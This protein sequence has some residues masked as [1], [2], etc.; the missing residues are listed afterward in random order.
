MLHVPTFIPSCKVGCTTNSNLF[1]KNL[2]RILNKS[3][4]C[5]KI[6]KEIY[7]YTHTHTQDEKSRR[8]KASM[9]IYKEILEAN[10]ETKG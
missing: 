9:D 5:F 2:I 1:P 6:T 8:E 4:T 7:I 10:L 3:N